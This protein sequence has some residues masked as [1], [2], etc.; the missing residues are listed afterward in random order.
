M[1]KTALLDTVATV[2]FLFSLGENNGKCAFGFVSVA[3]Y[4]LHNSMFEGIYPITVYVIRIY[5]IMEKY[6]IFFL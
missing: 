1:T 3:G 5:F 4:D 6:I 2:K